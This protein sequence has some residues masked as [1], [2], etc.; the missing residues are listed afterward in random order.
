MIWHYGLKALLLQQQA[1]ARLHNELCDCDILTVIMQKNP[2][3]WTCFELCVRIID[4]QKAL[5]CKNIY[6]KK[7]D[8]FWLRLRK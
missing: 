2:K 6:L 5:Q 8:T 1:A 4:M 7:Q 3:N